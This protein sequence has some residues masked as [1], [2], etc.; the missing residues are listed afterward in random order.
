MKPKDSINTFCREMLEP[1]EDTYQIVI[2]YLYSIYVNFCVW[3]NFKAN[4][5]TYF[6]KY[7]YDYFP[8]TSIA[9]SRFNYKTIRKVR[10]L[11][12]KIGK[13]SVY[14]E[15][16]M[17][18]LGNAM[19][20]AIR[21]KSKSVDLWGNMNGIDLVI[22]VRQANLED[23]AKRDEAMKNTPKGVEIAEKKIDTLADGNTPI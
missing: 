17:K 6:M 20:L 11:K 2:P 14:M 19:H 13:E 12:F 16:F 8:Y 4:S 22:T 9:E 1:E 3:N 21:D 18:A 15:E 5:K 23:I 7:L 10:G